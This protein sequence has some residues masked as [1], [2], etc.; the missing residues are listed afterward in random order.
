MNTT[1]PDPPYHVFRFHVEFHGDLLP[2][3]Q[4]DTDPVVVAHGAFSHCSGL[5]ATMEP[6]VVRVGGRNW[7][8][9]QRPGHVSFSTVVLRRG[10]TSTQDLWSWFELVAGGAYHVR[11][12]ARITLMDHAGKPRLAWLLSRALPV[13]FK[14]ADLDASSNEVGVEELHLAHEGL[15]LELPAPDAAVAGGGR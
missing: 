9:V 13:K 11:R 8:A 1:D 10:V 15:R 2:G 4:G 3:R 7:G 12:A 14:A 5:E 6:K